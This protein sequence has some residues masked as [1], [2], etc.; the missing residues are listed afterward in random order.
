MSGIVILFMLFDSIFKFIQ[1]D[2]VVQGT[3]ELGFAEHH[4]ALIGLLGLMSILLYTYPQTSVLGAILLT[5]FFGG[6]IATHVRLDNPL[7]S[8]TLFP[9][10]LAILAWGGIWLRDERVRKLIPLQ[11][12]NRLNHEEQ[13]TPVDNLTQGKIKESL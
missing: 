12:T 2:P 5:G 8:H 11:K 1:P 4:I 3:L 7:F 9:V 10:F 6:V 13:S